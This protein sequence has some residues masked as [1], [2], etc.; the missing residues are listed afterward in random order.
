MQLG[1]KG[2]KKDNNV[3]RLPTP[4]GKEHQKG[5]CRSAL[6]IDGLKCMLERH[7][8]YPVVHATLLKCNNSTTLSLSVA[9]L[10]NPN[11]FFLSFLGWGDIF[12]DVESLELGL[13]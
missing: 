1:F 12:Y 3:L 6:D 9:A 4:K 2:A 13:G 5:G 8:V 11:I 7:N 10:H